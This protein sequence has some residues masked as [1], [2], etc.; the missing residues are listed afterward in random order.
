FV[1]SSPVN[2]YTILEAGQL[3]GWAAGA[4]YTIHQGLRVGASWYR[5]PYLGEDDTMGLEDARKYPA[6]GYGL[7]LEWGRGPWNVNAELQRFQMTNGIVEPGVNQWV[8]YGEV[9]RTLSPRWYVAARVG[10]SRQQDASSNLQGWEGAGGFRP[11]ARQLIK[12]DYE[13]V[14]GR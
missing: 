4:G 11:A 6:S 7:D 3:G 2:P 10:S 1:N 12:F 14:R 13:A 5:G 9:R 8:G